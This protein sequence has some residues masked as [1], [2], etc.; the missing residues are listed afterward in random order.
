MSGRICWGAYPELLYA[1]VDAALVLVD[2]GPRLPGRAQR[3]HVAL[4]RLRDPVKL[5][6]KPHSENCPHTSHTDTDT[7]TMLRPPSHGRPP[8]PR[9]PCAVGVCEDQLGA[10]L[11]ARKQQD[12]QREAAR[13]CQLRCLLTAR[14]ACTQQRWTL[15]RRFT[16]PRQARP[17]A[18]R[19]SLS[20]A[21]RCHRQPL[22]RLRSRPHS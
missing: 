1:V 20:E 6:E 5:S 17:C 22:V 7:V 8:A 9:L 21:G 10:L 16:A 18:T 3:G 13:H 19:A 15:P 4:G 12:Q 2:V 14:D 11:P